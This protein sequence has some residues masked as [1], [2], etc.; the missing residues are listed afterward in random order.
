M[1]GHG[2]GS[3]AVP[4]V[5]NKGVI[6]HN[7]S[8]GLS[9]VAKACALNHANRRR[10]RGADRRAGYHVLRHGV[11]RDAS[12]TVEGSSVARLPGVASTDGASV[13]TGHGL[14]RWRTDIRS[15]QGRNGSGAELFLV[16]GECWRRSRRR[17]SGRRLG[18]SVD[19][20]LLKALDEAV[21]FL[22]LNVDL[23]AKVAEEL[24]LHLVDLTQ[25]EETLANNG[26]A[27]VAVGVV[28]AALACKHQC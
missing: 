17:G 9:L 20:T 12:A 10:C 2:V 8:R 21:K 23:V 28:A 3:A 22:G 6:E 11:A 15:S 14:G 5:G 13:R 24:A 1:R 7:V 19:A 25:A 16:R 18:V 26:P 27:L 4:G